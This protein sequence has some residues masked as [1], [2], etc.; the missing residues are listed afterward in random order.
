MT[1]P[2]LLRDCC[3]LTVLLCVLPPTSSVAEL[4]WS[5]DTKCIPGSG[6]AVPLPLCSQEE[7]CGNLLLTYD[8]D[9]ID[10]PDTVPECKSR[11]GFGANARD[12]GD[13]IVVNVNGTKR[14]Y[15]KS[16]SFDEPRPLLLY[17]HG[18][19]G[20]AQSAYFR[21][22]G[23]RTLADEMKY[24]L[25]SLQARNHHWPT[26]SSQDGSKFDYLHRD[27]DKNE[28]FSMVDHIID[29]LVENGD[30]D[31]NAIFTAGWSNGAHFAQAY[32]IVR[33]NEPTQGGNQVR[34]S[35]PFSAHDPF[36]SKLF[37]D[38]DSFCSLDPYP[39]IE[40]P[41][42]LYVRS[43]DIF[44]CQDAVEWSQRSDAIE[45]TILNAFD[46]IVADC[47]VVCSPINGAVNHGKFPTNRVEE[48]LKF[49]FDSPIHSDDSEIESPKPVPPSS[50]DVSS[51]RP[52]LSK[53]VDFHIIYRVAT[54]MTIT[55]T[56]AT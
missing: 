56:L 44:P 16:P 39:N 6:L 38:D 36:G 22:V 9:S 51:A 53:A 26:T 32:S 18:S 8:V 30:V 50:T 33:Y 45:L 54:A 14:Y 17:F 2:S 37:G 29:D 28:D 12:D 34:A 21:N 25:V 52:T 5:L 10:E 11:L 35:T 31:K 13:A 1:D 3:L 49:L 27:W 42:K 19:G 41:I 46:K 23:F 40:V 47:D 4:P 15:C 55:T 20:N 48:M 7:P 24:I 43:C